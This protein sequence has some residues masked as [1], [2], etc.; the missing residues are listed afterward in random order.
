MPSVDPWYERE[1]NLAH[2][3]ERQVALR[4]RE[5][6][7]F[8][9]LCDRLGQ[10][11][12]R[13]ELER[14]V[15]HMS[16]GVRSETVPV[17]LRNLRRRLAETGES[18]LHTVRGVGW[19]LD[20]VAREAPSTL[21][22]F[23]TPWFPR[24]DEERAV[25]ALL[26]ADWRVVTLV[27]PG[28]IGKS[29]LAVAVAAAW[30]GRVVFVGAGEAS[31]PSALGAALLAAAGV[32]GR[33]VEDLDG[34][35]RGGL[36]VVDEAELAWD[37]VREL[38]ERL[39]SVR[40][41]V[42][43]RREL[44][45]VGEAVHPV[46]P[47]TAEVGLAFL[48]SRLHG[49]RW[50]REVDD[51]TLARAVELLD[52]LPL[53]LE[54]VAAHPDPID[55]QLGDLERG[56]LPIGPESDRLASALRRSW[57]RLDASEQGLLLALSVVEGG[58]RDAEVR[59]W[60]GADALG[61]VRALASRS[62]VDRH[63]EGWVL[64]RTLR[65]FLHHQEADWDALRASYHQF[66]YGRLG[67]FED[68]LLRRPERAG[69]I[70]GAR[71]ADL[72]RLLASPSVPSAHVVPTAWL[73]L[74]FHLSHGPR[75][76]CE[77]V[78]EACERRLGVHPSLPV[79]AAIVRGPADGA[80]PDPPPDTDLE[81]RVV[82][83]LARS[84]FARDTLH[85]PTLDA[86]LAEAEVGGRILLVHRL[87]ITRALA[88]DRHDPAAA[89][90]VL[91]R[92]LHRLVDVPALRPDVFRR[93][94][95]LWRTELDRATSFARR[96]V[97]EARRCGLPI[98]E[99]RCRWSLSATLAERDPALGVEAYLESAEL[100]R[101]SAPLE[102]DALGSIAGLLLFGLGDDARAEPLLAGALHYPSL[103]ISRPSEGALA[104]LRLSRDD[105]SMRAVLGK[106]DPRWVLIFGLDGTHVGA[107]YVAM[108]QAEAELYDARQEGR[109]R[110]VLAAV[111]ARTRSQAAPTD[112][113]LL[114]V[115]LARLERR[116]A[117]L[118]A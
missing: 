71:L 10:I 57:D 25:R 13:E 18:P 106:L 48:R 54:L 50:H 110:E 94:A 64:L 33:Q 5:G 76:G 107:K 36:V 103:T 55:V 80:L 97:E 78:L 102:A 8:A 112:P 68:L 73:L 31:D 39:P 19:R 66:L 12:G 38:V 4:D 45:V 61:G 109:E 87:Q 115:T 49:S 95:M 118:E 89:R 52:G 81:T 111:V 98:L 14:E 79:M 69:A 114:R 63:G 11:V 100:S 28:G 37:A 41:V 113:G 75:L 88:L 20:P 3:G 34:V 90:E 93:L 92:F 86:L 16:P 46:R 42:T 117:E 51:T 26:D 91:E 105:P 23:E 1:T 44:G 29:R 35:L 72:H 116:L 32:N 43:S 77:R 30:T 85:L 65:T 84:D 82:A 108:L 74:W 101:A 2:L 56:D 24:D 83:Q 60:L 21:P 27:G 7:A 15:W 53:G 40:F 58:I 67:A 96:S 62:L 59:D 22:R 47:L 6:E 104:A 17:T 70:V 9:Y 99:T